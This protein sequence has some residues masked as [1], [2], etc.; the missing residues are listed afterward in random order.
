MMR[1]VC[2]LT[3]C[4]ALALAAPALA[5]GSSGGLGVATGAVSTGLGR[6]SYLLGAGGARHWE[7]GPVSLLLRGS[8]SGAGVAG[9]QPGAFVRANA[10]VGGYLSKGA[11][12]DLGIGG[13]ALTYRT[14]GS[15]NCGRISGIAPSAS[16]R[17]VVFGDWF[18]G[19]LGLAVEGGG[20]WVLRS[21][22]RQGATFTVS[23]GPYWAFGK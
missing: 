4:S 16:A 7:L 12:L 17:L 5:N 14:C 22:V 23:A 21:N 6:G 20:F 3:T 13:D 1:I 11:W 19:A 8:A 2:F 9:G 18:D 15:L 10:G